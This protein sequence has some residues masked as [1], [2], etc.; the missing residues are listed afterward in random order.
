MSTDWKVRTTVYSI[1]IRTAEKYCPHLYGQPLNFHSLTHW[2][3]TLYRTRNTTTDRI[4]F[5]S[6]DS[7]VR[8][9]LTA[10]IFGQWCRFSRPDCLPLGVHEPDYIFSYQ[11]FLKTFSSARARRL[12]WK[13]KIKKGDVKR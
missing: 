10:Y 12:R 4:M 5:S 3:T 6:T 11:I 9:L 8:F 7:K 1:M 2:Q 13:T